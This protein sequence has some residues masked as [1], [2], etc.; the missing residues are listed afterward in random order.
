MQMEQLALDYEILKQE[1]HDM[2]YKLEQSQLQEQLK[3]Q[4][5]CSL[6][7]NINEQEDQF[8]SLENELKKQSEENSDSLATIKELETH[9]KSLEEELEKQAQ[10]FEADLE[11][12]TCA[13]VEQEKRAIQAEEA[14]RKTRLKNANAAEKLQE[15]FRRLSVQMASTF[16]ANEKVAMKALAEASELRMQKGQLEE[17]LQKANEELQS[18]TD[19]YESKTA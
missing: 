11:A 7:P 1:N 4:Y 10:E 16:D 14:L 18:I 3:M 8:E 6:F 19:V 2:S 5:E 17:M 12:V 15:E 13:R 9:I